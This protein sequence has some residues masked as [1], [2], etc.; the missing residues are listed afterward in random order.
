MHILALEVFS[1]D[2]EDLEHQLEHDFVDEQA[3]Q[4]DIDLELFDEKLLGIEL[5]GRR[6]D[7][8]RRVGKLVQRRGGVAGGHVLETGGGD[9]FRGRDTDVEVLEDTLEV[10][11]EFGV[12][13]GLWGG[14]AVDDAFGFGVDEGAGLAVGFGRGLAVVEAV[15]VGDK[16]LLL[17]VLL[18]VKL[19][20]DLEGFDDVSERDPELE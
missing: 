19:L 1:Q 8:V 14:N 20:V 7:S 9:V 16:R 10:P 2:G 3:V 6:V 18:L 12:V 15:E 17:L 13:H 11:D 5:D 4:T